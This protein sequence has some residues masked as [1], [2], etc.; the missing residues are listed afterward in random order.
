[1]I[2]LLIAIIA[3]LTI[4]Q[5]VLRTNTGVVFLAICTG[6]VLLAA[7]GKDT[8]LLAHSVGSGMTVSSNAVQATLVLLPGI[9][10][11]ILLRKRVPKHKMLAAVIPA[12]AAAIVAITL[13]YPFLASGLQNSL[14]RSSG[15]TLLDQY[16]ELIVV[17]GTVA[18]LVT[19]ALTVPKHHKDE[20]K[21][22]PKH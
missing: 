1:M 13:T 3:I 21:H 12:L 7:A 8:D 9:V 6:S 17:V 5:L 18:S 19:I 20:K 10:S 16:Y 22:K 15:W 2:Y 14:T 11:A 4:L